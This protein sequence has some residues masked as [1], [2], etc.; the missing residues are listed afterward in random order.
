[1]GTGNPPEVPDVWVPMELLRTIAPRVSRPRFQVLGYLPRGGTVGAAASAVA[2]LAAPMGDAFPSAD[3]TTALTLE[4]A[5]VFC[6]TNDPRF[7]QFVA[8][9]MTAV[10]L[11]LLIACA[12]LANMLLARATGRHKEIAMRLALGASRR[13]IVRQLLTE[14]LLLALVGGAAGLAFSLWGARVLWLGLVETIQMFLFTRGALLISLTPDLRVF[15]YTFGVS[16]AAG[17]AFGLS[18]A[19]RASKVDLNA[20]LKEEGNTAGRGVIRS[21]LRSLLV[22][23]QVAGCSAQPLGSGA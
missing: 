5:S 2:L 21:R 3:A 6:E 1:I 9:L 12:N 19:L 10:G 4:R 18:P 23:T 20:A 15:A 13:R 16:L 7:H 8:A 14:S 22:G 11:V 17:L